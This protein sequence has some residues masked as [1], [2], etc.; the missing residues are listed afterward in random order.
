M[1]TA[2]NA[3]SPSKPAQVTAESKPQAKK[4]KSLEIGFAENGGHIISHRF[5]NSGNMGGYHDAE[6]HA[7]GKSEG[8]QALKHIAKHMHIRGKKK[9]SAPSEGM[10]KKESLKEEAAEE[11][12]E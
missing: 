3:A 5:D 4:L 1:K 10:E 8:H 6:D 9:K 12:E 7:F 11:G 2:T